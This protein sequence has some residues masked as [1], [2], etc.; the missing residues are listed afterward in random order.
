MSCLYWKKDFLENSK[1][2]TLQIRVL[3]IHVPSAYNSLY[4]IYEMYPSKVVESMN[5]LLRGVS[6]PGGATLI[7]EIRADWK[8]QTVSFRLSY[9][10]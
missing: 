6:L 4:A 3:G 5:H 1:T 10:F 8:C 9:H 7:P 2:K